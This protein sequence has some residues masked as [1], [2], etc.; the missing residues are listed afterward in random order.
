MALAAIGGGMHHAAVDALE[1]SE[2]VAEDV[3]EGLE[4]CRGQLGL[5][6]EHEPGDSLGARGGGVRDPE[7]V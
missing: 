4:L 6:L 3:L 1:G 5:A 2:V 7:Y